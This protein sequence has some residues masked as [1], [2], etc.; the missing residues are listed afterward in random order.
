MRQVQRGSVKALGLV[1]MVDGGGRIVF[2][3]GNVHWP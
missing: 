2:P 3:L 1:L